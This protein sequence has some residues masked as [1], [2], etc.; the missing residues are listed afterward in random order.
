MTTAKISNNKKNLYKYRAKAVVIKLNLI[1]KVEPKI[2]LSGTDN[3][4]QD[5]FINTFGDTINNYNEFVKFLNDVETKPC[6]EVSAWPEWG[7]DAKVIYSGF[8]LH[9]A[10]EVLEQANRYDYSRHESDEGEL[11]WDLTENEVLYDEDVLNNFKL[12]TETEFYNKEYSLV[13]DL[14]TELNYGHEIYRKDVIKSKTISHV[15][16]NAE[17]LL[18]E[19]QQNL[20]NEIIKEHSIND[21][22]LKIEPSTNRKYNSIN[23]YVTHL[24]NSPIDDEVYIGEIELRIANHS[25]NPKNNS[26]NAKEGNFI[27][28]VIAENDKTI[29]KYHGNF[30]IHF[31]GNNTLSDVASEVNERIEEIISNWNIDELYNQNNNI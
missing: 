31:N 14:L 24:N 4:Y 10:K 11:T 8:S 17:T 23:V 26:I 6:Y 15:E 27:S 2:N 9:K 19:V 25:Y 29:N 13:Q 22:T 30:N 21:Y 20:K 12:L 18:N 7:N 28:V 3:E 16:A 5:E 1:N